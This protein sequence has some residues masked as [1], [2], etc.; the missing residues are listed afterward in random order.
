M[1]GKM[2]RA[3][4]WLMVLGI[5]LAGCAA[6]VETQA[7]PTVTAAVVAPGPAPTAMPTTAPIARPTQPP[8]TET[9]T[10]ELSETPIVTPTLMV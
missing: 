1:N 5:V 7:P 9:P 10:I 6:P 3:T 2:K 4:V 8:A